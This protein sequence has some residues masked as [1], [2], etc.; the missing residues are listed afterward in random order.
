MAHVTVPTKLF[1]KNSTK[2]LSFEE[3]LGPANPDSINVDLGEGGELAK[4]GLHVELAQP[5]LPEDH[6]ELAERDR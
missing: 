2:Y 4:T 6:Q 1:D 3:G 5:R